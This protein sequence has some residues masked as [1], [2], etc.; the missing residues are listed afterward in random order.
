M[1]FDLFTEVVLTAD[2]PEHGVRAGD[3]ATV[4]ERHVAPGRED[5][6]S[7]EVFDMAGNTVAVLTVAEGQLRRP[8]AQDLPSVRSQSHAG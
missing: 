1:P 4:V 2:L 7:I 3:V 5:G 8:T 6:Y